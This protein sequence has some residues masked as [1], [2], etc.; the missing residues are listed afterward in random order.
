MTNTVLPRFDPHDEG[1][2]DDPYAVYAKYRQTDPVH[3][4]RSFKPS[5]DGCWYLF[6]HNH[7][8]SMLR[9]RRLRRKLV[10]T[11]PITSERISDVRVGFAELSGRLLLSLDP[12]DHERL[13]STVA[14][15]FTPS[16]IEAY[17]TVTTE[18]ADRLIDEL[19]AGEAFDVIDDYAAPLS[20]TLIAAIL[21]LTADELHPDLP[22]W[23]AEFGGGFDLR[24]EP[25]TMAGANDAATNMLRYFDAAVAG[26]DRTR[27]GLISTLITDRDQGRL[28]HEELLV[29]CVQIMF[30]GHGTTVAQVGNMI[31]DLWTHP[32][33]LALLREHPELMADAVNESLRFNGSVQSTAAR[34]PVEDIVL[35]GAHIR[36]GQP[37]IAFVGAANRDPEVF[38]EP[39][40][41][42]ITRDH[43][44]AIVFG[45]GIHYCLGA[46]LARLECQIAV[47]TLM[48]RLPHLALTES[49]ALHRHSNIV[50]P[51][52]VHLKAVAAA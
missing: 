5:D 37:L 29:L 19:D 7:V 34:K 48:R 26:H 30:A 42:D 10:P 50:L 4:G 52:L 36:A 41:F 35:G 28:T 47:A 44:A 18:T 21:G 40:R 27:P 22:Q 43:G 1:L 12:P 45:A 20:M 25:A 15:A 6:R 38:E 8:A 39:D 49:L 46:R 9:D 2:R 24:K 3:W 16:A 13:R 23:V 11:G 14:P 51:A 17:R 31:A 32:D 33:Q